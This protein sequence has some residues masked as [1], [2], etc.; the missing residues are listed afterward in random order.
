ME[1]SCFN[2]KFENCLPNQLPCRVCRHSERGIATQWQSKYKDREVDD[3]LRELSPN[4]YQQLALRTESEETKNSGMV[5]RLTQ[6]CLGL[7]GE[8]GE[9][10][11][12]LKKHKY[13]GHELDREHFAKE[14]GDVAWYLA[15]AADAIGC[16]LDYIFKLNIEKLRERYPDGFD[17]RRSL[18][19]AEGDV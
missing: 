9:C 16:T 4:E 12:L 5:E 6:G 19:R 7:C 18:H 17:P 11:D 15:V 14:L 13:H 3:S 1:K 8:A 2:C 10:A